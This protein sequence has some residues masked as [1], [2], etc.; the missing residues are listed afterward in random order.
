[1]YIEGFTEAVQQRNIFGIR[2]MMKNSLLGDK[3]FNEFKEMQ[4][5][6]GSNSKNEIVIGLYEEDS[7]ERFKS[8]PWDWDYLNLLCAEVVDDFTPER[9]NHIKEVVWEVAGKPTVAKTV[10]KD[11]TNPYNNSKKK[12]PTGYINQASA[13]QK[14]TQPTTSN[15]TY[16]DV[17]DSKGRTV[18]KAQYQQD[19]K[20]GRVSYS[21]PG[22][23][24]GAVIGG[25]VGAVVLG[26]PGA[27]GG[28]VIG[29][30]IGAGIMKKD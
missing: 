9:L 23:V 27:V 12:S 5:I 25:T 1:M 28:A 13:Q 7:N 14:P 24:G 29:G 10:A 20:E 17:K 19:K 22:M 15:R 6:V 21:V 30:A 26:P 16:G 11:I 2:I 3:T 8:R 18:Y 4:K